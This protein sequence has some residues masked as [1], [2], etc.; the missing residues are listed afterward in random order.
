LTAVDVT[1]SATQV[2]VVLTLSGPTQRSIMELTSPDRLVIDLANTTV[3]TSRQYG[4]V[5]VA[6]HGVLRVRWAP[7]QADRPTARIVIDL[8]KPVGFT[9]EEASTALVFQLRPK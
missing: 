8:S 1:M 4:S 7:F 5:D 2:I 9:V 6:G 3:A